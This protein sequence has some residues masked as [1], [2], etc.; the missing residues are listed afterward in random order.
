MDHI[1]KINLQWQWSWIKKR[2]EERDLYV[3]LYKK[4]ILKS[5]VF[6]IK[7]NERNKETNKK[8]KTEKK[9]GNRERKEKEKKK[10][11]EN[12]LKRTREQKKKN[13]K[14]QITGKGRRK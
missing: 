13:R 10:L 3:Q 5:T 7:D 9:R 1:R 11:K 4:I 6:F 2:S 12:R 8:E 14:K